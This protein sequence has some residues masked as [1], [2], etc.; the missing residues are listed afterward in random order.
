M[1]HLRVG[2]VVRRF[3]A[4]TALDGMSFEVEEGEFYC[5][6]GPSSAGKTTTLR[7]IAGLEKLSRGRIEFAGRDVTTAPVQGRGMDRG[8]RMEHLWAS[9]GGYRPTD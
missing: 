4:V 8:V 1:A 6:L 3:G 9:P 7:A 5:L 2:D